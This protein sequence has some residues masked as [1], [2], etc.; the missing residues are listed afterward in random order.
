MK[1]KLHSVKEE[2]L[3]EVQSNSTIV[4][5]IKSITDIMLETLDTKLVAEDEEEITF[6]D[7]AQDLL[8]SVKSTTDF[9]AET[10]ESSNLV[11]SQIQKLVTKLKLQFLKRNKQHQMNN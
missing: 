2:Y 3:N 7:T 10:L 5:N 6:I 8:K 9:V 4:N 11:N 1:R